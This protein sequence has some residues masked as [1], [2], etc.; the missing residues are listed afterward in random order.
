[1]FPDIWATHLRS[2][3]PSTLPLIIMEWKMGP[4]NISFLSFR[5]VFHFHD[6][7]RKSSLSVYH[8]TSIKSWI[9]FASLQACHWPPMWG[10]ILA[11]CGTWHLSQRISVPNKQRFGGPCV[12]IIHIKLNCVN[13]YVLKIYGNLAVA[14][15]L[16]SVCTQNPVLL[17]S[18]TFALEQQ[19]RLLVLNVCSPC[20]NRGWKKQP[21]FSLGDWYHTRHLLE[22]VYWATGY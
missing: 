13:V 14:R 20:N 8:E 19:V 3:Y 5:V 1:M 18:R 15:Y 22:E 6:Y 11:A 7:G 9:H 10:W 2:L 16:T 4:S 21:S 17:I 12:Y